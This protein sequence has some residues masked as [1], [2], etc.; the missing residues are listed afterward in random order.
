MPNRIVRE[1]IINSERVNALSPGA[2]LFYRRLMSIVDDFGRFELQPA[3]LLARCYS[4]QLDRFSVSD[5]EAWLVECSSG[6][7]PL[8]LIYTVGGKRFLEL[9]NFGQRIRP[10]QHSKF[11]DPAEIDG[12]ARTSA[13]DSGGP[14]KKTAFARATTPT[15]T[16]TEVVSEDSKQTRARDV[17]P[18]LA[19]SDA[20]FQRLLGAF[21]AA[22][23]ALNEQDMREAAVAWVSLPDSEHEPA[24]AEAERLAPITEARYMGLP[25]SFLHKRRW[26]R[27]GPGRLLPIPRA[28]AKADIAQQGAAEQFRREMAEGG[29]E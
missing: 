9:D 8:I 11:P 22:G 29:R 16:P 3:I 13:G 26:T 25:A 19:E 18:P 21:L 28:P 4:L 12:D 7:Q 17:C 10:G 1:N 6:S 20:L 15:P 2:E 14:P 23:V 5:I 27:R 24:T